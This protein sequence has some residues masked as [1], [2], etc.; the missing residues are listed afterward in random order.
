MRKL[1]FTKNNIF[2]YKILV[3][4]SFFFF[5]LI[6][7]S[8]ISW[9]YIGC[10]FFIFGYYLFKH[11]NDS[12]NLNFGAYVFKTTILI[13]SWEIGVL[14]W[15]LNIDKGLSALIAH[16]IMTLTF[17]IFYFYLARKN[18]RI[19]LI[20][21]IPLWLGYEYFQNIVNF[22]FPWL[23]IGNVFSNQTS[24][25]QWY[26]YIGVLGGSFWFLLSSYLIF[27]TLNDKS[28]LKIITLVSVFV[29]PIIF[30]FFILINR[31]ENNFNEIKKVITF[32]P[33]FK[34]EK[35]S[36][37]ELSFYLYSE[38][39]KH[40][41]IHLFI[42]PEYTFRGLNEDNFKKSLTVNF[43][44]KLFNETNL[45]DIYIGSSL[46]KSKTKTEKSYI[47]N[48]SIFLTREKSYFKIKKKLVP[49]NEYTP[50]FF[51]SI[52]KKRSFK[53]DVEDSESDLI[54]D[55]KIIPL[56]CYEA[57]FPFFVSKKNIDA[58]MIYLI[59]SEKFLK[60]STFGRKQYDNII[61]L[62]CIENRLP[63]IKSSSYG[64]SYLINSYGE[65][66]QKS[67]KEFNTFYIKI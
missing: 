8:F 23:I 67:R 38:L 56:I 18:K 24:I 29:L 66:K 42:A 62:R 47:T 45:K 7:I 53:Y 55:E 63:M 30:S 4:G 21:F 6:F 65:V 44:K 11:L 49:F 61:K 34:K 19:R 58:K 43:F 33:E 10:L 36:N 59:S 32:N 35:L 2:D 41:N 28:T 17:F 51:S 60:S 27:L 20:L 46:S 37:K 12:I 3:K 9:N 52:I 54:K 39:K 5:F 22:S 50:H 25:I 1:T 13:S 14:F 57:F 64:N 16:L 31:K 26:E 15:M 48:G 40:Q